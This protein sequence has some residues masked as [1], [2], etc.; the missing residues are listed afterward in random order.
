M[1]IQVQPSALCADL[2]ALIIR[3]EE[4]DEDDWES[5]PGDQLFDLANPHVPSVVSKGADTPFRLYANCT[6][7]PG[8]VEV[9]VWFNLDR[10][11]DGFGSTP[12]EWLERWGDRFEIIPDLDTHYMEVRIP[13]TNRVNLLRLTL[14]RKAIFVSSIHKDAGNGEQK[15]CSGFLPLGSV[16][17][18]RSPLRLRLAELDR[19]DWQ[20][21]GIAE[22]TKDC[23]RQECDR[24]NA[25]KWQPLKGT[26]MDDEL[27][28]NDSDERVVT[29]QRVEHLWWSDPTG[30]FE[31]KATYRNHPW[32][33]FFERPKRRDAAVEIAALTPFPVQHWI[34]RYLPLLVEQWQ[35]A[36]VDTRPAH[37]QICDAFRHHKFERNGVKY[38]T[39]VHAHYRDYRP[40]W[41]WQVATW[42]NKPGWHKSPPIHTHREVEFYEGLVEDQ[43]ERYRAIL[44]KEWKQAIVWTGKRKVC[45]AVKP[46]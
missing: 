18:E 35:V 4:M 9:D 28:F 3:G 2:S 46:G 36:K 39:A 20:P 21:A 30:Y 31:G 17:I 19:G 43:D 41:C 16:Q 29:R 32:K 1:K 5:I 37:E 10:K 40:H 13:E 22:A 42:E 34:D 12:E 14:G 45:R 6:F 24:W 25:T 26:Y 27:S 11:E 33:V 7:D 38:I 23:L 44:E 15:L 8:V